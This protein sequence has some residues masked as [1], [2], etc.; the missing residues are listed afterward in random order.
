MKTIESVLSWAYNTIVKIKTGFFTKFEKLLIIAN[1]IHPSRTPLFINGVER[2][3][4]YIY[5][6]ERGLQYM[7]GVERG[8]KFIY[9]IEKG[10]QYIYG[11]KR[12]LQYII[13]V[14]RGLQYIYEV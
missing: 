6:I 13:G 5:G 12:G 10:L 1:K 11:V 7:Y 4:Q 2:G 8:L 9:E 14:K 3:L